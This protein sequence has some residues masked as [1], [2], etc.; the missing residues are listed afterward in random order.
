MFTQIYKNNNKY[1][2]IHRNIYKEVASFMPSKLLPKDSTAKH[3]SHKRERSGTCCKKKQTLRNSPVLENV[4]PNIEMLIWN[5]T[6][7]PNK[8]DVTRNVRSQDV[9]KNDAG[10]WGEITQQNSAYHCCI[11][12]VQQSHPISCGF[13]TARLY[14]EE[15]CNKT[16][17]TA[18]TFVPSVYYSVCKVTYSLCN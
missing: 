3:A 10:D 17:R 15:L 6:F 5:D 12:K 9:L 2:Y 8:L 13:S 1:I 14:Q 4:L 18:N 16:P 11:S 7:L